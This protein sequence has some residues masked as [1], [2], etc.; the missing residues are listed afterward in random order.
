MRTELINYRNETGQLIFALKDLNTG[1]ILI[2]SVDVNEVMEYDTRA[3]LAYF[4]ATNTPTF[5]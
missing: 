1:R 3:R 5:H 2:K 4:I